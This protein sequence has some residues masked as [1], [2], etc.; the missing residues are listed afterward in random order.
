MVQWDPLHLK[1]EIKKSNNRLIWGIFSCSPPLYQL[2]YRRGLTRGIFD[3]LNIVSLNKHW[4]AA[5]LLFTTKIS[6]S[7]L[8][9]TS[10]TQVN[11]LLKWLDNRTVFISALY[12]QI[13][14]PT[15]SCPSIQAPNNDSSAVSSYSSL[16]ISL[17]KTSLQTFNSFKI[18]K[19]LVVGAYF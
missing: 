8:R 4:S 5:K 18:T 14:S 3:Y 12:D 17:K 19:R 16:Y 7:P 10:H 13:Y 11:Y 6:S 1:N 15:F 2:S 9:Q